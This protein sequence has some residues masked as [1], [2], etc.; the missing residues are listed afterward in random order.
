M[1]ILNTSQKKAHFL[2]AKIRSMRKNSNM[3]LEDLVY[4]CYQLDKESAPSVPYL[5]LIENGRRYPTDKL[6]NLLCELFH[7]DINWF[8][9]DSSVLSVKEDKDIN[10]WVNK[11]TLEPGVLFS[12]DMLESSIP[13]ILFQARISGRQFVHGLIR[14]Y[15]EQN[16]NSFPDMEKLADDA[17]QKKFPLSV[18]D[19]LALYTQ[20][21]IK[22]KWFEKPTF[23]TKDDAGNRIKTLFRSFYERPNIVYINKKLENN[24]QRLKYEMALHLAHKV[25]HG[26]DGIV[27]SHATGGELGGSTRPTDLHVEQLTQKDILLAWR[28]F[29]CS[30]FADALLCPRQPFR[31]FLVRN[32]YDILSAKKLEL[33]LGVFM[34]RI[35]V[36]SPYKH[37]HYFD[38]YPPGR[39]RVAFRGNGIPLPWGSMQ[40]GAPACEQ[41]ALFR[42]I[43]GENELNSLNQISLLKQDHFHRL[44][45]CTAV[46]VKDAA[47]NDHVLSVGVDLIP[48]LKSRNLDTEDIIGEINELCASTGSCVLPVYIVNEINASARVFNISWIIEGTKNPVFVICP[49]RANCPRKVNCKG[50]DNMTTH[51]LSW[52]DEIKK[53]ILNSTK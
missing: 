20:H 1:K 13:E 8:K 22:I 21:K 2:G 51:H 18:N 42:A 7:K 11:V 24:P 29:E 52:V 43:G 12:K 3:T 45:S 36:V 9:N 23:L 19:L 32:A 49:R 25:L 39:L 30:F 38:I 15:Q 37:W 35:T 31:R 33:T 47:D 46:R 16:N 5:S 53:D 14:T 26:G 4:R 48:M 10:T 28:D 6:L 41:W 17:G 50:A 40:A 27:S 34:R 44:Y